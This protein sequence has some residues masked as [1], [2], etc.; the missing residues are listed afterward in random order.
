MSTFRRVQPLSTAELLKTLE[1]L[2]RG[3]ESVSCDEDPAPLLARG[4]GWWARLYAHLGESMTP[5]DV[6]TLMAAPLF[7]V[8]GKWSASRQLVLTP[9]GLGTRLGVVG[10]A[11]QP[12]HLPSR[13]EGQAKRCVRPACVPPL[14]YT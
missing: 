7:V 9:H 5:A 4:G 10:H 6:D 13:G 8:T 1:H 12:R 3:S 14:R 2:P 11:R